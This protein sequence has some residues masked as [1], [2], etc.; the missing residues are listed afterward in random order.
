MITMRQGKHL[1]VAVI[2]AWLLLLPP[3]GSEATGAERA[4]TR[5]EPKSTFDFDAPPDT[6]IPLM[7]GLSFGAQMEL[8][9]NVEDNFDLDRRSPD[10]L[11]LLE[12]SIEVALSYIPSEKI[13]F[14]LDMELSHEL[15]N[16]EAGEARDR[17]LLEL[18]EAY[19]S[20]NRLIRGLDL[21]VGRQS[22]KDEREW[23]YDDEMDAVRLIYS[24]SNFSIDL[25]VSELNDRQLL[26]HEDE[27]E[28]TNFG[29]YGRYAPNEDTLLGAYVFARNDRQE[30]DESPVFIGLHASGELGDNLE[31][32]LELA[33]VRGRSGS[34]RIRGIGF[35]VGSTYSFNLPLKPALTLGYALGSGDANP[36]DGRDS[37]FRQ[38]G[39]QE[40]EAR[41][42]G[43]T[44]LKYYGEMLDPELSNLSIFTAGLGIRPLK[45]LSIDFI[46]H[47]YRQQEAST[48]IRDSNLERDPNGLSPKLGREYDLVAG[49]RSGK[50]FKAKLVFGYFDPGEAFSGADDGAFFSEFEIEF[51]L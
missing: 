29:L 41:F 24:F 43:V 48:T 45:D 22:F 30:T 18:V 10:S 32:W 5:Q 1:W 31:Y 13:R 40:N 19:V 4:K 3:M 51:Q 42:E 28:I 7:P 17:T 33:H 23:L 26:Q 27:G 14:F 35:D 36:S 9:F 21:R 34:N 20:L 15:V 38:T 11:Y 6:N 50:H 8:E 46:Y 25:S 39:L 12:P 47:D 37:N 16:D 44:R 49:Y 2:L